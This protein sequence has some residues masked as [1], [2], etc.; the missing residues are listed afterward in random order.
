M[1][2]EQVDPAWRWKHRRAGL[3]SSA[4]AQLD[5]ADLWTYAEALDA[6]LDDLDPERAAWHMRDVILNAGEQGGAEPH[7]DTL[8][9]LRDRAGGT[10]W[11]GHPRTLSESWTRTLWRGGWE[12]VA[13]SWT[14]SQ[15]VAVTYADSDHRGR[16]RASTAPLW[17]I[18]ATPDDVLAVVPVALAGGP[19]E[20]VLDP[21][22]ITDERVLEVP[23]DE[24]PRPLPRRHG[25]IVWQAAR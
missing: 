11:H 1:M 14:P 17:R 22:R 18:E 23:E 19:D 4:D 21:A 9:A 5:R 25:L 3:Y 2:S 16:Q 15:R 13:P 10:S 6:V 20:Y 7:L 24:H 12:P 8:R